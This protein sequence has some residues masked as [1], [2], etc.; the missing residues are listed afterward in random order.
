MSDPTPPAGTTKSP[1]VIVG[2]LLLI[3]LF[4]GL[5]GWGIHYYLNYS[6]DRHEK[7]EA[8]VAATS[9]HRQRTFSTTN[10]TPGTLDLLQGVDLQTATVSGWWEVKDRAFISDS[11][12]ATRIDLGYCPPTEYDLRFTFARLSGNDG[13][14]T[15]LCYGGRQFI[16]TMAGWG[17]T[18]CGFSEISAEPADNNPTTTRGEWFNNGQRYTCVIKVIR[19][20]NGHRR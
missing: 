4:V 10:P 6:H 19:H 11:G 9:F 15:I 8:V 2:Q 18:V 12:A 16:W 5:G 14:D 1:A 3:L 20:T 17:N 13:I 7:R